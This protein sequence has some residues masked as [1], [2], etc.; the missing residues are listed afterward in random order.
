MG[1]FEDLSCNWQGINGH[2]AV[3]ELSKHFANSA[4]QSL[5]R[6]I[7]AHFKR[8][9]KNA[10]EAPSNQCSILENPAVSKGVD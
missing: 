7:L 9:S 3:W 8:V 5:A 6:W 4:L 1:V 10:F 2:R